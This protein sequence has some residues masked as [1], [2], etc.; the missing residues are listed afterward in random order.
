ME[1]TSSR[2]YMGEGE[3]GKCFHPIT[4]Q[5]SGVILLQPY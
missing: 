1:G 2:A 3:V 5:L 4:C